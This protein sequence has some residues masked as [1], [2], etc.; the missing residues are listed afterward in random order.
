[1][2]AAAFVLFIL[3]SLGRYTPF[4][5][6]LLKLP[7]I[8]LL[9][10]PTKYL[11]PAGLFWAVLVGVGF[12]VWRSAWPRARR[13][14]ALWLCVGMSVLAL[15]SLAGA[16]GWRRAPGILE[17]LLFPDSAPLATRL[18]GTV[19]SLWWSASFAGACALLV[20][21]RARRETAPG[22]LA[23][24]PA[25]LAL[26]D[27]ATVGR[28]VNLLAPPE[29]LTHR[30]PL[31]DYLGRDA[32]DCRLYAT[33]LFGA[34]AEAVRGPRGWTPGW[35]RALGAQER[36][37]APMG[38]RWRLFGSYDGDFTGLSP[39]AFSEATTLMRANEDTRAGLQ[40]LRLANVCH[41]VSARPG[42]PPG[43]EL[44]AEQPSV[45]ASPLRL[46]RIP[47]PQPRVYAVSGV[48]V[49]LESES[50]EILTEPSFDATRD[51]V[52]EARARATAVE[53]RADFRGVARVLWR[54]SNALAVEVDVTA[55]GYLVVV[56]AFDPGWRAFV[57]GKQTVVL[58]ANALFRAVPLPAGRHQVVLEYRSRAAFWGALTSL[59]TGATVV[60]LAAWRRR[61]QGK[62]A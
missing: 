10:F 60:G 28:Q 25:L 56:E 59:L 45:Y 41:V 34:S 32:A 3:A 43:A 1:M 39:I 46:L 53:A 9:R 44:V 24:A 55:P 38:A 16:T 23:V 29:L 14:R 48:R 20:W 30:P 19:G 50:V 2:A 42:G 61:R 21:L 31:L 49:A 8:G 5:G 51:V 47:D 33:G 54:R 22:W 35:S 52:L 57:D 4:Y 18:A 62:D 37:E 17:P 12:E 26:G 58:R 13:R 6:W 36:L 11:V 27:L 15:F 40:L 7:L